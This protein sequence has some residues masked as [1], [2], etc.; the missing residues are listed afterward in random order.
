MATFEEKAK[1]VAQ[2]YKNENKN[3]SKLSS[4]VTAMAAAVLKKQFFL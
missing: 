2:D 3:Y 1:K 4:E